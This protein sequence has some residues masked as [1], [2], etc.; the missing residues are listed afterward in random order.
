MTAYNYITTPLSG[1]VSFDTTDN[2][3]FKIECV[4]SFAVT[5]TYP[6][7]ISNYVFLNHEIDF[8]LPSQRNYTFSG[9]ISKIEFLK[10]DLSGVT[11]TAIIPNDNRRLRNGM[12]GRAILL[13]RNRPLLSGLWD[14]FAP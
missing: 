6:E 2:Y 4:D 11:V 7:I 12:T 9:H 3:I 1:I 5:A 13:I 8:R 14:R 10:G